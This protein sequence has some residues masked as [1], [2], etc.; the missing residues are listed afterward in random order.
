VF[1]RVTQQ[2]GLVVVAVLT[3]VAVGVLFGIVYAMLHHADP[4][5]DSWRR[6]LRLAGP[7]SSGSRR[8]RSCATQ[9]TP[10]GVGD[11]GTAGSRGVAYLGA[12]LIGLAAIVAARQV[13]DRLAGRGSAPPVQH[14]ATLAG[15]A[16]TARQRAGRHPHRLHLGL[17][18]GVA[19]RAGSALVRAW[20][21]VRAARR[22]CRPQH[23]PAGRAPLAHPNRLTTALRQGPAVA[24]RAFPG[25]ERLPHK[26][27]QTEYGRRHAG[28]NVARPT[29]QLRE[30]ADDQCDHARRR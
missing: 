2:V 27:D 8:S 3:G 14:L 22:A 24:W 10:P 13:H 15:L 17:P 20:R 23:G 26:M 4:E 29:G 7:G 19:D 6:A 1:S 21:R 16:A 12:V 5:R 11:P 18:A 9:P 30:G 28:R 25:P